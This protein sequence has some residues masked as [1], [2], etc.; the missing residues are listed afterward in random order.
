MGLSLVNLEEARR[1]MLEEIEMDVA[2]DIIYISA[3]LNPHGVAAYLPLFREAVQ[4][5]DDVWLAQE[6]RFGGMFNPAYQRQNHKTGKISM[7]T[8]PVNAPESLAE[9]E[10]NRF[11]IRGLSRHAIEQGIL[12]LRIYRARASMH[13]RPESEARIGALVKPID[14][15]NDL[16]THI[17]DDTALGVPGGVNSGLSVKIPSV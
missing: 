1:Y 6:L 8:M 5:H 14:L 12:A 4:N 7:V 17:G 13:P 10:F 15:L 9:G 16:R 3:R 2:K 11:Y